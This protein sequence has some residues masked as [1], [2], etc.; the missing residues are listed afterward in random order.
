MS[1]KPITV[2]AK[3]ENEEWYE[4]FILASPILIEIVN[5]FNEKG[6]YVLNIRVGNIEV[7]EEIWKKYTIEP[8][9]IEGPEMIEVLVSKAIA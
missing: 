2:L 5:W 6:Y 1:G 8:K 4:C 9:Y 7:S 3:E